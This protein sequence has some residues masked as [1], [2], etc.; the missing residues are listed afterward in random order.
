NMSKFAERMLKLAADNKKTR[1][2]KAKGRTSAL[3]S[4]SGSR[5]FF[6]PWRRAG[7]LIRT[8]RDPTEKAETGG[9]GGRPH[10]C[11]AKICS[12]QLL[13]C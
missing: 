5:E 13:W 9:L 2:T 4:Q 10:R 1:K 11:R 8:E 7:L 6:V 12:P 3:L